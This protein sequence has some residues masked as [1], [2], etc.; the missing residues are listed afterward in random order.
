MCLHLKASTRLFK[1]ISIQPEHRQSCDRINLPK[2]ECSFISPPTRLPKI[3]KILH[4]RLLYFVFFSLSQ[5]RYTYH[6]KFGDF[7]KMLWSNR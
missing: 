4:F 3:N 5:C 2:E 1:D 6:K 7:S